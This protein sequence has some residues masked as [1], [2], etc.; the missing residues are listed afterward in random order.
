M[1]R[2]NKL[3]IVL[4]IKSKEKMKKLALMFVAMMAISFVSCDEKKAEATVEEA[5]EAVDSTAEAVVDSAAAAVDS[6]VAAVD[7][8]VT[9]E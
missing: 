3:L 4:Q 1:H 5:V 6:V 8:A 9:A 2:F 7:S